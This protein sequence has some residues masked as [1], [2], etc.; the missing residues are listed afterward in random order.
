M[1]R[2]IMLCALNAYEYEG[3]CDINYDNLNVIGIGKDQMKRIVSELILIGDVENI[4]V[5]GFCSRYKIL[6][7]MQC[8][9]FIFNDKL[10]IGNKEV[11]MIALEKLESFDYISAK[12]LSLTLFDNDNSSR[13]IYAIKENCGKDI[14]EILKEMKFIKQTI[15]HSKYEY[16]K[17][18]L[19]LQLKT[20]PNK[21]ECLCKTCSESNPE[22]FYSTNKSYCKKC[23]IEK[24]K[25][26]DERKFED[27]PEKF[28]M[29]KIKTSSRQRAKLKI[30][31]VTEE[32]LLDQLTKQKNRDFYTGNI[33]SNYKEMSVDRIDSSKGYE[34]GNIVITSYKCNCAKNDMSIK[35]FKELITQL[36][37]NLE[38]F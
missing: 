14:F 19:G 21:N 33:F 17:T 37:N 12:K 24:N 27:N 29:K 2:K 34:K 23:V 22:N 35:E 20:S 5:N 15:N 30:V 18:P 32:D 8:P 3:V 28:L 1:R 9:D 16:I 10:T 6:T 36:Y 7:K 4:T 31:T 26:T 38:N 11:L 13:K 25:I